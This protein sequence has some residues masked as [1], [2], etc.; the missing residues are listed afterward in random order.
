MIESLVPIVRAHAPVNVIPLD[1][2]NLSAIDF[3]LMKVYPALNIIQMG[4]RSG[5]IGQNTPIVETSSGTMGL[6]LAIVCMHFRLKLKIFGDP[7]IEPPLE[8]TMR[9]LGAEVH[10]VKASASDGNVQKMRKD[11]LIASMERDPSFWTR[12]YDHPGNREAYA[13]PAQET[14]RQHGKVDILVAPVG[15]G[16]SSCG[17][18][19]YFRM[20]FPEMMLVGV[21][22]FNSVLFGQPAGPRD[23]RGLGNSILPENLD[24]TAF[25]D[26]NWVGANEAFH[27]VHRLHRATSLKRGPTSGAAYLVA[28]WYADAYPD[29]KVLAVF[30]DDNL[31]Y[32]HT[33]FDPAWM[34]AGGYRAEQA[35]YSPT[36]VDHPLHA[37]GG[38]SRFHWRRRSI[39]EVAGSGS[40]CTTEALS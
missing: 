15:S 8:R 4:L 12:Q 18:S 35:A 1:L 6:G 39:T 26:I 34:A 23:L 20:F 7:A 25:D 27:S 40:A 13:W 2:P 3:R 19:S 16:G 10:I 33:V 31:R 38:W 29:K 21:D 9:E 24:H 30:P 37:K 5:E 22:T 11:A 28:R 17:L 32:E 36:V 14:I